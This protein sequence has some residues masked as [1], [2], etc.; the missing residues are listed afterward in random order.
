MN[1]ELMNELNRDAV[2]SSVLPHC[3]RFRRAVQAVA[4]H[5]VLGLRWADRSPFMWCASLF[6]AYP[7]AM[8][9]MS[10][11]TDLPFAS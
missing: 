11:H 8:G 5:A 7:V 9:L 1:R 4:D 6:H 2:P 10:A 3:L